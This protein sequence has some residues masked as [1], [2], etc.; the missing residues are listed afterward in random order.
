[1]LSNALARHPNLA[2]HPVAEPTPL[3]SRLS[4]ALILQSRDREGAVVLDFC[5]GL[6]C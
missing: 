1:M 4:N 5:H 3:R 6:L 2:Y